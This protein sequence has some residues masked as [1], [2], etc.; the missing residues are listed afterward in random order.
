[1]SDKAKR[2]CRL[3]Q[4]ANV[5]ENML[6]DAAKCCTEEPIPMP[7]SDFKKPIRENRLY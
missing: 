5:V 6:K 3:A 7:V 2:I 4:G 1:M